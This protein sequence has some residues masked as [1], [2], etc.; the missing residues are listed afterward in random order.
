MQ[1]L[2]TINSVELALLCS[3]YHST[4]AE[5]NACHVS[6]EGNYV[7]TRGHYRS[8]IWFR[9]AAAGAFG[10]S[11]SSIWDTIQ[12][13]LQ[14][15]RPNGSL[16]YRIE[17]VHH[18]RRYWLEWTQ[19]LGFDVINR[20]QP[21]GIYRDSRYAMPVCD[22]VPSAVIALAQAWRKVPSTKRADTLL[23]LHR[24]IRHEESQFLGQTYGLFSVPAVADWADDIAVKGERSF[25]N[26]LYFRAYQVI[27]T[28]CTKVSRH[29]DPSSK[30]GE[31]L[32]Q[33]AHEYDQKATRLN[34]AIIKHLRTES[35]AL[36]AGRTD[37][38]IDS[39]S[40]ALYA[41][42]GGGVD[43]ASLTFLKTKSGFLRNFS[44][45]YSTRE[46]RFW[47]ALFG[48]TRFSNKHVYPWISHVALLARIKRANKSADHTVIQEIVTEVIQ[49]ARIH[50]NNRALHE[51]VNDSDAQPAEH[52]I[53]GVSVYRSTPGFLASLGTWK[54]VLD[55]LAALLNKTSKELYSDST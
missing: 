25:I 13:L 37:P 35:G 27:S 33:I 6:S 30:M 17:K 19:R 2:F 7:S 49:L 9:D 46:H 26:V 41:L 23:D 4:V 28:L 36:K 47:F 21:V 32:K 10:A 34:E 12:T 5:L 31:A 22:T 54:A 16:P 39:A 11:A 15:Q 29:Q 45:N 48:F 8:Q 50:H 55:G 20:P 18:V 53:L 51:V 14:Y 1:K 44:Q 40:T 52:R 43:P 3:S 38:R 24:A 42:Y